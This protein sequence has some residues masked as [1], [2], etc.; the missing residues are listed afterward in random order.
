[1]GLLKVCIVTLQY[2]DIKSGPGIYA[3]NIVNT[4]RDEGHD[5]TVIM[6]PG[7]VDR[8]DI[9]FIFAPLSVFD[10]TP[11]K[12]L[13]FSYNAACK[14]KSLN[15]HFDI[16]H[17]SDA[18]E[19]CFFTN[20]GARMVGM[21][22]GY[23]LAMASKDP[24]YYKKMYKFDWIKRYFYENFAR[25]LEK[26][27]LSKI[28]NIISNT[29]FVSVSL[30]NTYHVPKSKIKVI[31]IG[32]DSNL[33]ESA[34]IYKIKE[35]KVILFV[36]GNFQRKGLACLIKSAPN[37]LEH[38]PT[39]QFYVIG[40]DPNINKMKTLCDRE[41]VKKSFNFLGYVDNKNL[42]NYYRLADIFV[43]PSLEEAFGLV[44]LEAM[45]SGVPVVGG[46]VG[47]VSEL[48][49]NG[50]NGLL[51]NP[52]DYDHLA[53]SILMLLN[54]ECLRSRII[55]EGYLTAKYFSVEK[56]MNETLALYND[57]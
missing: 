20:D 9:R 41:G 7:V 11:H 22:N 46:N 34:H 3:T 6:P 37:V 31:Y 32:V 55:K 5:V 43:M 51:I 38:Y 35:Q 56:M 4:L 19:A 2:K 44:F 45:A 17:F 23:S 15:E 36:G 29:E 26:F 57:V 24:F 21:V 54:N 33:Y 18:K 52:L 10:P 28:T 14:Y 40:K 48:I 27:A 30:Q 47:G 49:T 1:M 39:A 16:V 13:S 42:I 50:K 53:S 12:W 25:Q 8:D